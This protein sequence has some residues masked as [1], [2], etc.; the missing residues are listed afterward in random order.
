MGRASG[1]A[2]TRQRPSA[3]VGGEVGQQLL[4]FGEGVVVGA[5]AGVGQQAGEGGAQLGQ[6]AA[7]GAQQG[8]VVLD[9]PGDQGVGA[10]HVEPDGV[11]GVGVGEVEQDVPE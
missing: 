2:Q 10:G 7:A 4:E 9:R 11:D 8:Q 3:M 1:R 6:V 5:A